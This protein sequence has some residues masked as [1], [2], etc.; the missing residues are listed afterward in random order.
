LSCLHEPCVEFIKHLLAHKNE[1][2]APNDFVMWERLLTALCGGREIRIHRAFVQ[3]GVNPNY[4]FELGR[5]LQF[6]RS[7]LTKPKVV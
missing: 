7:E 3:T 4:S 6:G 5:A 2:G 1:F